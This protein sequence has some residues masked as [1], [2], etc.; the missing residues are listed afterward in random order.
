MFPK[1]KLKD[2]M[3]TWFVKCDV[4]IILDGLSTKFLDMVL[5]TQ[6]HI[7]G[8]K[9]GGKLYLNWLISWAKTQLTPDLVWMPRP[10]PINRFYFMADQQTSM[11][12]NW[13][14]FVNPVL[15]LILWPH[16]GSGRL[17]KKTTWTQPSIW[18]LNLS[19][20]MVRSQ[21]QDPR[22]ALGTI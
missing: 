7:Y 16:H 6:G 19:E 20:L 2:P 4:P 15:A 10:I 12:P 18:T 9:I 22:I 14:S 21:K 17:Q 3:N 1:Y 5:R 8:P 13:P 11:C